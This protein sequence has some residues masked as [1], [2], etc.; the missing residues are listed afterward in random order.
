MLIPIKKPEF[1]L[2]SVEYTVSI[3]FG[4]QDKNKIVIPH[5]IQNADK[6]RI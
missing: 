5:K 6:P 3:A 2:P 1:I 4:E